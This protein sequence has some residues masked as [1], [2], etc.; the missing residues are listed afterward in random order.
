[1]KLLGIDFETTGLQPES[2]RIIEVGAVLWCTEKKAPI[3]I[4]SEFVW[5]PGYPA[6]S[7]EIQRITGIDQDNLTMWAVTPGLALSRLAIFAQHADFIV[8]HNGL[9]FDKLFWFEEAR[10]CGLDMPSTPWIDTRLDVPYPPHIETRKL[11][12][13][14]AEHGFLNPFAHRALFDVLAMMKVLGNYDI[15]EVIKYASAPTIIVRAMVSYDQRELAKK[16]RYQWDGGRK[17]WRKVIKDFQ[18]EAERARCPFSVV[19][20]KE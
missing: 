8:A 12:L 11:T 3:R 18:L 14:A 7:D 15:H 13:L 17:E 4:L 19:E 2:D 16:E 5:M 9:N 20:I 1:M 6:L 10:R